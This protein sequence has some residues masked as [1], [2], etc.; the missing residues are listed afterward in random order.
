MSNPIFYSSFREKVYTSTERLNKEFLN[1]DK[2]R[3]PTVRGN[4]KTV[5]RF[6]NIKIDPKIA[7]I[8]KSNCP[9]N[10]EV[11]PRLGILRMSIPGLK[12]K[13]PELKKPVI[14][15]DSVDIY[16]IIN[17]DKKQ[18]L[19]KIEEFKKIVPDLDERLNKNS[20]AVVNIKNRALI[21]SAKKACG[22]VVNISHNKNLHNNILHALAKFPFDLDNNLYKIYNDN[23]DVEIYNTEKHFLCIYN[24]VDINIDLIK[25]H[26]VKCF[27]HTCFKHTII[28]KHGYTVLFFKHSKISKKY[29]YKHF[30]IGSSK[31]AFIKFCRESCCKYPIIMKLVNDM[32]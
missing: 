6:R 3:L 13:L 18:E 31:P 27:D 8:R 32:K 16:N 28:K 14:K 11:L 2:I 1:T 20:N 12:I 15:P 29:D 23:L 5:N 10:D 4:K 24:S 30:I 26:Y 19:P 7:K 17:E 25:M 9:K 22:E 21:D